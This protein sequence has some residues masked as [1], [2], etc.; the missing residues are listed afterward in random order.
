MVTEVETIN[1]N[2][3]AKFSEADEAMS[4][5]VMEDVAT[6]S[7]SPSIVPSE[8]VSSVQRITAEDVYTVLETKDVFCTAWVDDRRSL[9][10]IVAHHFHMNDE[11]ADKCVYAI[12]DERPSRSRSK[13]PHT[14]LAINQQYQHRPFAVLGNELEAFVKF[15]DDTKKRDSEHWWLNDR[16]FE[17]EVIARFRPYKLQHHI[18]L[19][20][21]AP[22]TLKASARITKSGLFDTRSAINDF[23]RYWY[24]DEMLSKEP[25]RGFYINEQD[26]PGTVWQ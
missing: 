23:N 5:Q 26:N 8:L 7:R 22:T 14:V 1:E 2:P 15:P 3:I 25:G 16:E 24:G 13:K 17:A 21:C 12:I 19:E 11:H 18:Q 4:E 10:G 20:F 9:R 6:R